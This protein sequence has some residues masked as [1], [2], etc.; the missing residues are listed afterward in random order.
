MEVK[1][2]AIIPDKID[3][4]IDADDIIKLINA[5]PMKYRWNFVKKIL[6]EIKISELTADQRQIIKKYLQTELKKLKT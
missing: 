1:I 3:A 5:R 4:I 2:P 6:D